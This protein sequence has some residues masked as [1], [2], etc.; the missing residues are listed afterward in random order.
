[1][2]HH[3]FI[4]TINKFGQ[5]NVFQRVWTAR[6]TNNTLPTHEPIGTRV[7]NVWCFSAGWVDMGGYP[8]YPPMTHPSLKHHT[9]VLDLQPELHTFLASM[10]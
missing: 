4:T 10:E 5:G 3:H 7:V 6:A 8:T 9:S 2:N 1:M